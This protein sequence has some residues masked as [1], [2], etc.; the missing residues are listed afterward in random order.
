[1]PIILDNSQE[2]MQQA[3]AAARIS[4]PTYFSSSLT[5]RGGATGLLNKNL[6]PARDAASAK[7]CPQTCHDIKTTTFS[8]TSDYEFIPTMLSSLSSFT[9][10]KLPDNAVCVSNDLVPDNEKVHMLALMHDM[11]LVTTNKNDPY[12]KKKEL[13]CMYQIEQYVPI[14][15]YGANPN[16]GYKCTV[17]VEPCLNV[18][19]FI[20]HV[21]NVD[22]DALENYFGTLTVYDTVENTVDRWEHGIM[23]VIKAVIASTSG[24]DELR[25][26]C[27]RLNNYSV[28]LTDYKDIYEYVFRHRPDALEDITEV[29][30]NL[31][32]NATLK[33]LEQNKPN[34]PTFTPQPMAQGSPKLSNEQVKAV[35]S[36]SPC[37]IVQAGAGTGKSTVIRNRINYLAQCG[38]DLANVIVLSF[39]NA[40]AN[41]IKDIAP[42]VNS[43]TIASMI[44]DIY[45]MNYT[46]NLSTIDTMLNILRSNVGI[47]QSAAGQGLI[48]GLSRLR[49]DINSG[50]IDLS[51]LVAQ[52]YDEVIEILDKI[53]QTTLELESIIC[54]H[55]KSLK[56]PNALC[57][58]L[59]MDEVQDN[60]IFEFIYVI[61]YVVRH[62]AC[63]YL[64]GDCSQTLYE[65]RAS[66]PKALNCLEMSG[67]FD[68]MQLQTNY[69]SNQNIL[70]FANLTLSTIEANQFARIQLQA[71]N[72]QR[73][74]FADDVLVKYRRLPNK[75]SLHDQLPSM[76]IEVKSWIQ[77]KLDKGQ[78]VCFLAYT[79]KDINKFESIIDTLFPNYQTINIVPNKFFSN[80]YFSKYIYYLG[81]DLVHRVNNDVTIE[82][83]RHL[84]DNIDR[85]TRND[86]Q[87]RQVQEM[88]GQWADASRQTFLL[89]DM[90]LARGEI[91]DEEFIAEVFQSL[92]EFEIEKNAMKQHIV[93]AANEKI[94]LADISGYNF[95]VSTIHSAKGLEFDNVILLYD[96]SRK[97]SEED[98][99]MYYVAQTRAKEAECILAFNTN[100][101]SDILLA[102]ENMCAAMA[103][104]NPGTAQAGA[105]DAAA[106]ANDAAA[107][108]PGTPDAAPSSVPDASMTGSQPVPGADTPVAPTAP[109]PGTGVP[110]GPDTNNTTA[111]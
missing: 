28:N 7:I 20:G 69:R 57:T 111:Q 109:V 78:Q 108:T 23:D 92:V 39:T 94:K 76:V 80:S 47:A 98:K 93:S 42:A 107:Q 96:E 89:R 37:C 17:Y 50:L 41:H 31:L 97:N 48:N 100:V 15:Q 85:I 60:S 70:D 19:Q 99:R 68:C 103:A 66:N 59:I 27:L 46:H 79:R 30:L 56:E 73:R 51:N 40:A 14:K 62:N 72:F 65:F 106:Q 11:V 33:T 88:I 90:C 26:I 45:S 83:M 24:S 102:Y 36:T 16:P 12:A 77:D 75:S 2:L 1:M 82:L 101:N 95:V 54:Y 6:L 43:K 91:T 53:N 32:L 61:N 35:T 3:Q 74:P 104:L 81:E 44:H 86:A 58:H 67:V 4:Y 110:A 34:I 9:T 5:G 21:R 71:N 22:P 13:F 18:Q 87:V 10:D 25:R 8:G 105:G 63:L 38:V 49:K 84:V 52:R 64:V 55:A 29:N